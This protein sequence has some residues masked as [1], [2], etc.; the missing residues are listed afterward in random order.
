MVIAN[1]FSKGYSEFRLR[2][3]FAHV[4]VPRIGT[5]YPATLNRIS[6]STEL[7]PYS[8]GGSYD[9]PIARRI[10]EEAGVP[11]EAFGQVKTATA[12]LP[13]NRSELFVG[14]MEAIMERYAGWAV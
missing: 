13:L 14:A 9:R 10:A 5:R 1:Q 8:L 12:P 7:A 4:P 3:G 6:R 2:V 11:R